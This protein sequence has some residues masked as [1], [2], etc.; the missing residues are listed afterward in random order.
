MALIEIDGL[1]MFTDLLKTVIF[2]GELLN[3]QMV[4]MVNDHIFY[5]LNL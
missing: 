4:N 2:H 5:K 3:N 1:P